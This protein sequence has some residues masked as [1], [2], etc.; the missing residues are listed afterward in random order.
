LF[1]FYCFSIAPFNDYYSFLC[2]FGSELEKRKKVIFE[3]GDCVATT[4]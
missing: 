4:F 3:L 1:F 2:D